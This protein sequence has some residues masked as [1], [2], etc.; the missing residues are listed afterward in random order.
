MQV[1]AKTSALAIKELEFSRLAHLEVSSYFLIM[2][3]N[4]Y[5]G[6]SEWNHVL[7]IQIGHLSNGKLFEQT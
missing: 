5:H 4:F 2:G 6:N 7:P 1:L 3:L